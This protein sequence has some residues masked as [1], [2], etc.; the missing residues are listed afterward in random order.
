MTQPL[1]ESLGHLARLLLG[2]L[3]DAGSGSL[4]LRLLDDGRLLWRLPATAWDETAQAPAF[5]ALGT[6]TATES[7]T[8]LGAQVDV[9]IDLGDRSADFQSPDVLL[10]LRE[11]AAEF[12]D[13]GFRL[14][15]PAGVRDIQR[16][17]AGLD[18]RPPS[19]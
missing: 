2:S 10:T 12:P 13:A 8:A 19:R 6:W 9:L 3:R 11:V 1:A 7:E 15:L 4:A 14:E 16:A 18:S 5:A 17:R